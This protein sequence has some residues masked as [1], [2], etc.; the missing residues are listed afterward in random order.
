MHGEIITTTLT[1]GLTSFPLMTTAQ[2]ELDAR[3]AT[4]IAVQ[5]IRQH[6]MYAQPKS[7]NKVAGKWI[8]KVDVGALSVRLATVEIDARTREILNYDIP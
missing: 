2:R 5:F 8:V 7:A 3:G 6:K 1:I 4:D